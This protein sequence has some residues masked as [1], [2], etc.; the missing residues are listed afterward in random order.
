MI[1]NSI[2]CIEANKIINETEKF[3]E[4]IKTR[5]EIFKYNI[6]FSVNFLMKDGTI[7]N[8]KN[9]N[10]HWILKY[11]LER[12]FKKSLAEDTIKITVRHKSTRDRKRDH[13]DYFVCVEDDRINGS[14]L[15]TFI[16][17]EIKKFD[18]CDT[19]FEFQRTQFGFCGMVGIDD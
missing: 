5:K 13:A 11:K 12:I 7:I 1:Q 14:N 17:E 10:F 16:F 9:D 15:K 4:N 18:K 3:V 8:E 2:I 6:L 19:I